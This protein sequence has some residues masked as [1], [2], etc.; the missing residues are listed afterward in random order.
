[1]PTMDD[2]ARASGFSQMTVSRAF[3]S[4]APIRQETRDRILE[5][6]AAIGYFPNRAA[7]SLASQRTRTFGII[8]PTLQDSIYLP[9]VEGAGQV[10]EAHRSDYLLQSIDYAKGRESHAI[11]ALLA[12]RVEAILLP[13]I[14]HT[15]ATG[16]FL[17]SIPIPLIEVGNLPKRPLEFAVGHSDYDAGYLATRRLIEGG[18]RKIAIICGEFATTT[19]ARDRFNGCR[20]A[21]EDAGLSL[22]DDRVIQVEHAVDAGLEGLARL[23]DAKRGFNGLVVAGEIWSAAVLLHILKSGKRVPQDIAIVGIGKVELAP[24]L[25]VPLTHVD[26]PRRET[27]IRSAEL[28]VALSQGKTVAT[29]VLKLPIHLVAMASG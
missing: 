16:R 21:M 15:V 8:L 9:F 27:G 4:S 7:S 20:Q 11:S 6:A 24:F 3:D 12:H 19:N 14:G 5:A 23:M 10:F 28:A 13:S 2:V 1:M 26:L 18:R 22:P 17:R 29:R 25:P